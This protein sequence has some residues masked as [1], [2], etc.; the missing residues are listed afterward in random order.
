MG[1]KAG[2]DL[3]NLLHQAG[4]AVVGEDHDRPAIRTAT[5]TVTPPAVTKRTTTIANGTGAGAAIRLLHKGEALVV[6]G[7]TAM[8]IKIVV[9][10]AI[11]SKTGDAVAARSLLVVAAVEAMGL[12]QQAGVVDEGMDPQEDLRTAGEEVVLMIA[13]EA[14]T[15]AVAEAMDLQEAEEATTMGVDEAE[16]VMR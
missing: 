14:Q 3:D 4:Q 6:E 8:T 10:T 7:A 1:R 5:A 15:S 2:E 16:A 9:T 11:R 12:H 13:E